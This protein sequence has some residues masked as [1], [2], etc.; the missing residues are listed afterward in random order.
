MNLEKHGLHVVS[1]QKMKSKRTTKKVND[2]EKFLHR[3]K[4]RNSSDK[5][6]TRQKTKT[7]KQKTKYLY[8]QQ[9]ET[10]LGTL[11]L[12]LLCDPD[13]WTLLE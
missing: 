12:A 2:K 9:V 7:N 11:F 5:R 1:K 8:V 3:C 13:E 4:V 6:R 10:E